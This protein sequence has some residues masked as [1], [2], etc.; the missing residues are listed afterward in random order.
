MIKV[1]NGSQMVGNTCI[2]SSHSNNEQIR[3]YLGDNLTSR[4]I[5]K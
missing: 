2:A 5:G 3:S 1:S 4:E